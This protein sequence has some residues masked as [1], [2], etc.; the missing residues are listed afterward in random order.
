[1]L[2][3]FGGFFFYLYKQDKTSAVLSFFKYLINSFI[4]YSI[5]IS[6]N[7][8]VVKNSITCILLMEGT[9]LS[10]PSLIIGKL[11]LSL[12]GVLFLSAAYLDAA[13]NKFTAIELPFLLGIILW[14]FIFSLYCFNF[15]VL[16]LLMEAITLLVVVSNTLYFVFTGPKLIKPLIQFF[17]LNLL[18]STFYLLGVALL[19]YVVPDVGAYTLSYGNIWNAFQSLYQD[20]VL[21]VAL[22]MS[23][24]L[25]YFKLTISFMLITFVFK[26]TLAPFSIWVVSVYSNLPFLFLF[27]IMTIYKI[28]YALLFLRLFVHVLGYIDVLHVF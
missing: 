18:M 2:A 10:H 22:E 23:A 5:T 14:L 3:I 7:F 27:L 21:G 1:M 26:L 25:M 9:L 11:V 19:L 28:V 13:H 24:F 4:L 12:L 20:T 17:I 15:I 6:L 16:F 8:F